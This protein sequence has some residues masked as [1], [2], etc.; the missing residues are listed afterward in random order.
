MPV[1]NPENH[2]VCPLKPKPKLTRGSRAQA[3]QLYHTLP[4]LVLCFFKEKFY[5]E[6]K[7]FLNDLF[8]S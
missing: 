1:A 3:Q 4:L 6:H 5:G 7:I 8:K 2:W